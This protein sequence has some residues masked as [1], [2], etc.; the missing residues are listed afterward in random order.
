MADAFY[1]FIPNTTLKYSVETINSTTLAELAANRPICKSGTTEPPEC[2]VD[3]NDIPSILYHTENVTYDIAITFTFA[4]ADRLVYVDTSIPLIETYYSILLTPDFAKSGIGILETLTRQSVLYLITILFLIT[5]ATTV[6]F[7]VAESFLVDASRL[8]KYRSL[9][10]RLGASFLAACEHVLTFGSPLELSS[11]V[12]GVFRSV[13]TAVTVFLLAVF[14]ALITSQL[15][16]SNLQAGPPALAD[17]RG[18]RIAIQ[19]VLLRDFPLSL[20][21]D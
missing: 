5:I 19:G 8:L 12:S 20:S 21:R 7:F 16:V 1:A 13:V 4:T 6:V 18:A 9:S 3:K 11:A 17:L 10:G 15:T 2:I 14:G